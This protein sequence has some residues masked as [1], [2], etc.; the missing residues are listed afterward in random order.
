M[1]I[2]GHGTPD[3]V[4]T[5]GLY[6]YG[7][8]YVAL[9]NGDGTFFH[10][11]AAFSGYGAYSVALAD[12]NGDGKLDIVTSN[13]SYSSITVFPG[14]GDGTFGSPISYPTGSQPRVSSR[15]AIS[16]AMGWLTLLPRTAMPT[17][18]R[19]FSMSNKRPIAKAV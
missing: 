9:G 4:G 3:A 8:I 18:C 12:F 5:D 17:A 1:H 13:V 14:N 15:S 6:G 2:N 10:T 16:T 7:N 19:S 11:G